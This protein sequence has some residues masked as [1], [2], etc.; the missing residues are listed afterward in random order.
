M[1]RGDRMDALTFLSTFLKKTQ[2]VAGSYPNN[3]YY[4]CCFFS[5]SFGL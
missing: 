3:D 4:C 2:D 1:D 5:F